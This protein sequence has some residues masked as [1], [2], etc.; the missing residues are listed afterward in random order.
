MV[1]R[2]NEGRDAVRA[3]IDE[4]VAK[5]RD[6][7]ASLVAA[8]IQKLMA[9]L[10]DL[11]EEEGRAVTPVDEWSVFRAMQHLA[12]SIER[13]RERLETLSSGQPYESPVIPASAGGEAGGAGTAEYAFFD[14]L[15]SNYREGMKAILDV[16]ETAD[17]RRGLELTAS[18]GEF[19]PFNWL[20]WSLYSHHV[21]THD[22]LDQIAAIRAAVLAG[23]SRP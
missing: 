19:G 20:Q 13:S 11:S 7:V 16:I 12:N 8:D 10:D 1:V 23:R 3:Y 21:H 18:H 5:G 15:R 9:M 6:H 4:N 17:P 2:I 22:H 14:E